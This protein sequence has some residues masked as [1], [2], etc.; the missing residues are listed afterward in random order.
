MNDS[1]KIASTCLR[2]ILRPV[3][4]FCLRRSLRIQDALETL[5]EVFVENAVEEMQRNNE[6]V[7]VSRLSAMTGLHRRDV[8]RLFNT[9]EETREEKAGNLMTRVVG[10]WMN[11]P[12][13]LGSRNRP[14]ILTLEGESSQF[15]RLVSKVSRDLNPGTV[16]FELERVGSVERTPRGVKLLL[17]HY[18]P[19]ENA[20]EGFELLAK[21]SE[22]LIDAVDQNI[23]SG[24]KEPNLH[25]RTEF[26]SI[27][28]EA[29]PYIR[30]WLLTEGSAFHKRVGQ[31]LAQF[32]TDF[33]PGDDGV[34]GGATVSLGTF[35]MIRLSPEE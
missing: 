34:R 23:F 28:P 16:L 27:R 18:V 14:R 19:L 21:D 5:K 35:S 22:D 24:L 1:R 2:L 31:F 30:E 7:N 13:F 26:D 17:H 25:G 32:D 8:M 29:I 6:K 10:Q 9:E 3:A 33:H 12:E 20:V 11:D 4:R 15:R